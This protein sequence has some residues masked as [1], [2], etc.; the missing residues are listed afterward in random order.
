[1]A[2]SKGIRLYFGDEAED[3]KHYGT[4]RHSGR[5]PWGSGKNPQRSRDFISRNNELKAQGV[6]EKERAKALLGS[7]ATTEDLRNRL[8]I[9]NEARKLAAVY[10]VRKWTEKGMSQ[11]EISRRT[12]IPPTTVKEYQ[13]EDAL[14]K[15]SRYSATA[16]ALEA[17]IKEKGY[18]Q[19]GRGAN[20][21]LGVTEKQITV[22]CQILKD[23]GYTV[24]NVQLDQ[25]TTGNKTSVLVA[26]KKGSTY[27]D[28]VDNHL[29]DIQP[30]TD[31]YVAKDLRTGE[32]KAIKINPP[33]S[34]NG[35]RVYIRYAEDGGLQ[36]DGTIEVRRGVDDLSLEN[37]HYAQVR[38]AVDG[39]FYMKGMCTYSGDI[40]D[41]YDVVY[42][43]NKKLG[44]P[45]SEVYKK[46]DLENPGNP[47]GALIRRQ[48]RYEDSSGGE[49]QGVLNIV[50]EEG[51]WADW[52]DSLP[53]QF[54][55]KQSDALAKQQLDLDY[56]NRKAQFEEIKS[57]TNPVVKVKM[58]EE[59]SDGCDSAA[60]KLKGAAL[61]KQAYH[62]LLPLTDIKD[63]EIYAPNYDDGEKVVLV[64]FPHGGIFEIPELT[65]NNKRSKFAK[66]NLKNAVDAVG[67]SSKV[68]EQLSGADFDGDTAIV[69]PNREGRIQTH[70]PLASLKDFDSKDYKFPKDMT[71]PK[72]GG[73]KTETYEVKD[74]DG[75]V[76][77]TVPGDG[78]RKQQEMG[79]I[80][81]LITDMSLNGG[82]SW[83]EIGRAV[84]YS[85]V[86]IDAEK[87]DLNWQ[88]A[89]S[90]NGITELYKKYSGRASGGGNTLISR[91]SGEVDVEKRG[92]SY[93][94]PETGK[95]LYRKAKNASWVNAEGEVVTKKQ[96][97]K[98]MDTVDD[99]YELLSEN[100]N[101]KE[102]LYADY[103][104]RCKALA[105]TA[106][107]EILATK[108]P[109]KDPVAEEKYSSEVS[110][111]KRKLSESKKSALYEK[112]AL[113]IGNE[114]YK[115][116]RDDNPHADKQE[117]KKMQGKCMVWAR[118]DLGYKKY[119]VDF[120]DKE[121]EAVQNNAVSPTLF[122]D[123]LANADSD[124][125]KQR[126]MPRQ[127]TTLSATSKSRIKAYARSG[128]TQEEIAKALGIS[129]SSVNDVLNG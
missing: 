73:K 11:M 36:R 9:T 25:L 57:L 67:I 123:L 100:P 8:S 81:N 62:V 58:L 65:V 20:E 94:D 64:R 38:I 37:S 82:A 121:W 90:D 1:M 32:D 75:K 18:I 80:S 28:I 56:K 29:G 115:T 76:V 85:M 125:I 66:E 10:E 47:F 7:N 19:V 84:K 110:S 120:T 114:K 22:A 77:G 2:E 54:L 33:I 49:K 39:K 5:Y 116:W 13:K 60:V 45:P 30:P 89:K 55:S 88:Q 12:G 122:R 108:M 63:N 17:E 15:A 43:T 51:E 118:N 61:P 95:K 70:E 52:S 129:T 98:R 86:V 26:A 126:A 105:N 127:S 104:N 6:S 72:V 74:S 16:D 102:I 103:A 71:H 83:D 92:T 41:G 112:Q 117:Q 87:H 113:V 101:K 109:K 46:M 42:N 21:V 79:K 35:K 3:L 14:N 93:I 128:Y 40:P 68:A 34:I 119:R 96:K 59:F 23:R 97:A 50:R 44:T 106:R 31:Y 69:I 48:N 4:P 27:R 91:A 111:L 53:S 107:K 78:F 99:A 124:K 24:T